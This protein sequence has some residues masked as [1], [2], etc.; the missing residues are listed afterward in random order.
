M[1]KFKFFLDFEK[2]EQWLQKMASQGY[3]LTSIFLGYRFKKGE[4]ETATIRKDFRRFENKEDFLDYQALFEDSGW[5]HLAGT[6]N[7]GDQYIKKIDETKMETIR[8][9]LS[10]FKNKE[11]FLDYQALYEDSHYKHLADT[12]NSGDQYFKKID[13]GVIDDIFS[14]KMS[15]AARYQRFAKM[16]F[17][18]AVAFIPVLVVFFIADIIDFNAFVNPKAL[19]LTQDLWDKTG[20]AFWSAFLFETPFA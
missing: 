10:K 5:K 13:E 11:D 14:D 4:P 20:S 16:C 15:K 17:E 18:L 7:S 19:Y 9:D 1:Y 12:K 6:K 2:E 8:K 3:H